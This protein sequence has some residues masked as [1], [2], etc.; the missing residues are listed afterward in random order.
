MTQSRQHVRRSEAQWREILDRFEASN[1]NQRDFCTS[2]DLALASFLRW[3]RRLG[4]ATAV[5]ADS[6]ERR[7][8]RTESS[9]IEL[10]APANDETWTIELQ[11]PGDCVL[12]MRP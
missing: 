8:Q 9:F 2:E 1:Q 7:S 10:A 12:R 11:L 5:S 6:V 3:R 4:A